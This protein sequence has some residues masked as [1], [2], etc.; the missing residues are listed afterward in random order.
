MKKLN[1]GHIR[2][3]TILRYVVQII[4]KNYKIKPYKVIVDTHCAFDVEVSRKY[5]INADLSNLVDEMNNK[6]YNKV[7]RH[8]ESLGYDLT[9]AIL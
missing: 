1:P 8:L 4:N 9:E 6:Y 5:D 7:R 2:D 3:L